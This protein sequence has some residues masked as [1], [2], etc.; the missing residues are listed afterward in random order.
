MS[1]CMGSESKDLKRV[2]SARPRHTGLGSISVVMSFIKAFSEPE[3]QDGS[4]HKNCWVSVQLQQGR[5]V[6]KEAAAL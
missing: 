4:G 3:F 1:K 6:C 5:E 2:K